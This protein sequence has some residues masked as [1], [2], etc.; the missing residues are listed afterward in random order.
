M[1]LTALALLLVVTSANSAENF[2]H[3][4][5]IDG[6]TRLTIG[7]S[8]DTPHMFLGG[9]VRPELSISHWSKYGEKSWEVSAVPM[10]RYGRKL[11]FEVGIGAAYFTKP[12]FASL[13]SGWQFADHIGIG[14][15]PLGLRA[16]HFSNAGVRKPNPGVN[17]LQLTYKER[18]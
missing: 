7:S 15:G 13:P 1:K 2:L 3:A 12:D 9:R 10:L 18:F 11:Y 8:I 17:V 16:S 14:Y 4:G 6:I 5:R